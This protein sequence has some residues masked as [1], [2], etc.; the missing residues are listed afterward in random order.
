MKAHQFAET[1]EVCVCATQT[2]C[3]SHAKQCDHLWVSVITKNEKKNPLR[4]RSPNRLL[5]SLSRFLFCSSGVIISS[6][7]PQIAR[8]KLTNRINNQVNRM[9]S[10]WL[11][12]DGT[13]Q[14]I[15]IIL[16]CV[17][18][19]VSIS[20]IS[21]E[22]FA[23][24]LRER[25]CYRAINQYEFF[26]VF[27]FMISFQIPANSMEEKWPMYICLKS[28]QQFVEHWKRWRRIRKNQLT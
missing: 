11:I 22:H 6:H 28:K 20:S 16:L 3:V 2:K 23:C 18:S 19:F 27:I 10:Y 26:T 17:W 24:I 21:I 12:F 5:W 13:A 14:L 7:T 25:V 15:E 1:E 4:M 9:K 8:P